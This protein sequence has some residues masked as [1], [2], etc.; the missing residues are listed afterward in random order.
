MVDLLLFIYNKDLWIG[1]VFAWLCLNLLKD[2]SMLKNIGK[3]STVVS[4]SMA[5]HFASASVVPVDLT[6][7]VSEGSGNW[8]V[9]ADNNSVFQ[10][11]NGQPTVFFESGTT[12]QGQ[13]L[14]GQ[15]TVET[16]GDDD[17]I[18]FVLGYSTGELSSGDF[19]LI[20][21]KQGDQGTALVGLS[22]SYVGTGAIGSDFWSHS[23]PVNEL[24]RAS[25]LGST[26]WADNTTYDFDLVFTSSLIQVYVDDVLEINYSGVFSDG[27]FGFYNYSQGSVRYAGLTTQ[28]SN[29]FTEASAPGSLLVFT[30]AMFS[31]YQRRKI[32]AK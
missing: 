27:A 8:T 7:W 4:L 10:S 23:A 25:N 11:Q 30:L 29:N 3:L 17:F 26:G 15:I 21:W 6:G 14:S 13:A 9:A 28:D 24:Q 31:L 22:L 2:V 12:S 1:R 20:D 18:G 16:T 32:Y 5:A 19:W